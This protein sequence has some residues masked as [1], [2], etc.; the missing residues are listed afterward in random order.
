MPPIIPIRQRAQQLVALAAEHGITFA[1][2]IETAADADRL[3]SKIRGIQQKK[4][5]QEFCA[6][7]KSNA[8]AAMRMFDSAPNAGRL[9]GALDQVELI[10]WLRK[11]PDVSRERVL[12]YVG[13]P[14]FVRAQLVPD[15]EVPRF[16]EVRG[17]GRIAASTPPIEIDGR[18]AKKLRDA[19]VNVRAP[20]VSSVPADDAYVYPGLALAED[21]AVMREETW[22]TICEVD[23]QARA[24]V[25][26]GDLT[27]KPMPIEFGRVR[28]Q[29]QYAQE[30]IR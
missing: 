21:R 29:A 22:S 4:V 3:E 10:A 14:A 23:Q 2:L 9:V 13:S 28:L 1:D 7:V 27:V 15:D 17:A 12:A 8:R 24:L 30:S 5:E 6:L 18:T 20:R 11:L 25:Q 16:V 26:S 19:G